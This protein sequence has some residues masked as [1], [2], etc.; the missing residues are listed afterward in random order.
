VESM[1]V[2]VSYARSFTVLFQARGCLHVGYV[3]VE[4]AGHVLDPIRVDF[5][6]AG[7]LLVIDDHIRPRVFAPIVAFRDFTGGRATR[8]LGGKV[9]P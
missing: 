7:V 5:P 2:E 9:M 6:D 4:D 3:D 8:A 1:N